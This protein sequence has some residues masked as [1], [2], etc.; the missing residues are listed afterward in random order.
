MRFRWLCS[1]PVCNIPGETHRNVALPRPLRQ[2]VSHVNLPPL[3]GRVRRS[4]SPPGRVTGLPQMRRGHLRG[5]SQI[6]AK[7]PL[8]R[9][10]GVGHHTV[11][12]FG[13]DRY[14]PLLEI[15]FFGI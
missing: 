5:S 10:S 14:N 4:H 13:D 7:P 8:N 15:L 6:S 2:T 9:H 11:D 12:N 1:T 3:P